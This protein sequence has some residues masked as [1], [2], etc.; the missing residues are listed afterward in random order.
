VS[1]DR[2]EARVAIVHVLREIAPDADV[3]ALADDADL[4]EEAGLDSIDVLNLV[5]GIEEQTGVEV[6]ARDYP[7][8]VTLGACVRYV[9]ARLST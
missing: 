9:V 6:P 2:D 3:D 7:Q 4:R 1:I 5:A 8:L